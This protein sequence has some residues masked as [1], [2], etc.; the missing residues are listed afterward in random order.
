MASGKPRVK[1]VN[2]FIQRHPNSKVISERNEIVPAKDQSKN[3]IYN[4][5]G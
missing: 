3:A 1:S 4:L 5:K 2:P